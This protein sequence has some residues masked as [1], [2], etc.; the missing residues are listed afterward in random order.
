MNRKHPKLAGH[1][2]EK[3]VILR[4]ERNV[5]REKVARAT[6][7]PTSSFDAYENGQS[8]PS[9]FYLWRIANYFGLP[10]EYF[11]DGYVDERKGAT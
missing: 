8:I 11:F 1:I 5:S 3:M 4:V 9:C 2:G 10:M 7:I 6:D